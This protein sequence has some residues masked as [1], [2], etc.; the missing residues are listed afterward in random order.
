MQ[1]GRSTTANL[2]PSLLAVGAI[3]L[4]A[5]LPNLGP[6][7]AGDN[8]TVAASHGRI[9]EIVSRRPDEP[10][11]PPFANVEIL[12]GPG[13]GQ[14][15][16]AYLEG[17]GG[18]QIVAN[19]QP[20]DEVL[21]TS[22]TDQSGQPYV[23]VADRWRAPLLGGYLLIFVIVVVLVG[24]LRGARALLSLG[25]TIAVILK[26]LVPLVISGVAPVPLAVV[27]AIAVTVV[28][29][30]L[31]EGWSRMS[32]AA[33]LGT[34][35]AL[36]LT[37][38]LAAAATA[39]AS[40]TYSA[41]SDLAFLQTADGQGLDLRG[42]LLAAI[43][44]GGVGVLDDVTVTQAAVVA[45][46]A[47]QGVRGR[48]LVDAAMDVGRSHIAATVNT[49]FLAY[50][51]VGLPL[52]VTIIVSNQP[53]A[54]VFNSEEVATEV[55]RTLVGSLGIVAAMPFTTIVAAAVLD[56]PP[57]AVGEGRRD[58]A[59]ARLGAVTAV[60]VVVLGLMAILPLGQ[61]R[62]A[63]PPSAF[64]P[65]SAPGA[66]GPS[67]PDEVLPSNEPIAGDSGAPGEP[68]ILSP[69]DGFT[70]P[71]DPT[72]EVA[73]TDVRASPVN[74]G[75][76]VEVGVMYR[77]TGTDPFVVDP[78]AW[79][80]LASD[81]EFVAMV[82]VNGHELQ[83]SPLAPASTRSA[84]LQGIV[85]AAVDDTFVSYSNAAGDVLFAVPA[86]GS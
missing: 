14:V 24:G 51:G 79:N 53:R 64:G 48:R 26:L 44:L 17:P 27:T 65:S 4:L 70:M 85:H 58:P 60:I 9:V 16:Q 18:S 39:F 38:L 67:A 83:T 10:F 25:L 2:F 6:T 50:V 19:Y 15:V 33:I 35:G 29:I 66:A 20:G 11:R 74:G 23:A 63:L 13:A 62:T 86:N 73:V 3:V 37:G 69:G 72:V 43:I 46:L 84:R 36:A 30:L 7:V 5:L 82:G 32:A 49:L 52:I 1:R 76:R 68:V 80:L 77:N 31:T 42:L 34:A 41:G 22:T 75:T 12:D 71:D 55:I 57:A 54:L 47:D 28:T 59:M 45:Q 8:Q 61:G 40:F 56:R 78:T 21:V 81:G